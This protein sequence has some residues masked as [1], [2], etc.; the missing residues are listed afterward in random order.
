M[1]NK[2]LHGIKH[3]SVAGS[4]AELDLF[5]SK[6]E[7]DRI[8]PQHRPYQL[9]R[10]RI[11]TYRGIFVAI[12]LIFAFFCLA[13]YSKSITWAH[14]YLFEDAYLVKTMVASFCATLSC[15]AFGIAYKISPEFEAIINLRNRARTALRGI[16]RT[17]LNAF[18]TH[19]ILPQG[20]DYSKV[21]QLKHQFKMGMQALNNSYNITHQL[22]VTIRSNPN[23]DAKTKTRLYNQ[24]I[25]EFNDALDQI[26]NDL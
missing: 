4:Y 15:C 6:V 10:R 22:M 8:G 16:Y 13:I 18:G 26:L 14:P 20:E 11:R 19:R 23:L 17:Q 3:F 9:H 1:N 12:G 21:M 24:A 7:A 2:L 5:R 25:F